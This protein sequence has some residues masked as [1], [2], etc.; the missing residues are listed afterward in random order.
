VELLLNAMIEGMLS[1]AASGRPSLE[2]LLLATTVGDLE[3]VK[4]IISN[5]K[6]LV[7]R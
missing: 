2:Q 4:R 3:N 7:R 1:G 5:N 6:G